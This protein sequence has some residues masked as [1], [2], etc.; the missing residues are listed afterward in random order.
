[1]A[2]ILVALHGAFG[3][4]RWFV[5]RSIMC[6]EVLALSTIDFHDHAAVIGKR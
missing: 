1:M 2:L 4:L 6:V 5:I 3:S